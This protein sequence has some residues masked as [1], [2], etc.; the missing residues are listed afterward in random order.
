VIDRYRELAAKVDAFFA[1][2][3]SRHAAD[4]RCAPGCDR[5]CHA[6]LTVTTVEA[7]AIAELVATLPDAE[8]GLL[9]ALAERAPDPVAPRCAALDDAGRCRI[10]AARPIVC[11]SHGVPIR[12][13]SPRGLPVVD[14]CAL[15]FTA[16]GP[17][18]ADPDCVL[19]QT[20]LSATLLAIDRAHAEATGR[21]PGARHDLAEV[22]LA[23]LESS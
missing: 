9:R 16:H 4:L 23:A 14:A 22:L 10:Y 11:R 13:R 19:D 2:V 18:A 15:N 5:C 17:A 7:D 3:A 21:P 12:M 6:R 1:R 20:T 8:R